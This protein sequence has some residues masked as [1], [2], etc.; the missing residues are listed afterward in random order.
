VDAADSLTLIARSRCGG[1]PVA[2]LTVIETTND[3]ELHRRLRLRFPADA[4]IARYTQM[5]VLK[6]YRGLN[7]PVRMV[8]EAHRQFVVPRRIGHTWLV[9]NADRAASSSFC[10]LLGFRPAPGTVSTEYGCSR[11]LIHN[12]KVP[13]NAAAPNTNGNGA[14]AESSVIRLDPDEWVAQ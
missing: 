8:A 11:V 12:E 10:R 14:E 1:E 9:F 4:R 5:A 3:R 6:P 2:V 13:P 7:L